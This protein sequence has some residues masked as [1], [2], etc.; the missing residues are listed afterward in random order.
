MPTSP[1]RMNSSASAEPPRPRGC[2]REAVL[3]NG[4][5]EAGWLT[6][7]RPGE[8]DCALSEIDGGRERVQLAVPDARLRDRSRDDRPCRERPSP[9]Y[10][11]ISEIATAR[12]V[13]SR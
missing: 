2:V 8:R 9:T 12:P 10:E 7:D 11:G 3:A 4:L 5:G 6:E 1:S 13:V